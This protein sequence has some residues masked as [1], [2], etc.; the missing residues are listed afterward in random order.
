[1]ARLLPS[2][3]PLDWQSLSDAALQSG[4]PLAETGHATRP[5]AIEDLVRRDRLSVASLVMSLARAFKSSMAS[6]GLFSVGSIEDGF[7][8]SLPI[9]L[10]RPGFSFGS[11]GS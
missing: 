8:S 2:L 3:K 4:A 6:F 11:A 5:V 1:M 10:R 9:S 7:S